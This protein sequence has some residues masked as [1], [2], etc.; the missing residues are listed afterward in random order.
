MDAVTKLLENKR[1]D[2]ATEVQLSGPVG[3]KNSNIL[4]VIGKLIENGFF[5]AI[6]PGFDRQIPAPR[7]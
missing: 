1:D 7:R 3:G 2:V 6:L 4:Q 5:N